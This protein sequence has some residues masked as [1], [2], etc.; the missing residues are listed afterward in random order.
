MCIISSRVLSFAVE[1][2]VTVAC[3]RNKATDSALQAWFVEQQ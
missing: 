1:V 3:R 2:G